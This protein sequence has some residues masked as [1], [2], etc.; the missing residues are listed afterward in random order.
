MP[1][2]QAK[3]GLLGGVADLGKLELIE[4]KTISSASSAIFTSI[5]ESTYNVHFLTIND[6][7]P[8]VDTIQ[9]EI[10]FFENGVEESASVYQDALQLG[11]ATGTFQEVRSTARNSIRDMATIG[12]ATNELGN[13]YTYF[14]NLGDSSKYS[15]CTFHNTTIDE[16]GAYRFGFGSAVLPQAS[17]VDQIKIF[18]TSGTFDATASLYGIRYS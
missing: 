12:N 14:Y 13:S 11:R 6:F 7:Q 9:C 3:F 10:R 8:S 17:L 2:G 15:F 16:T 4:T 18:V 1:I 5:Q